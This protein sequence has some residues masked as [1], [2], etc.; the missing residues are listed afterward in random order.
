MHSS[1][2][3]RV[4]STLLDSTASSELD[5]MEMGEPVGEF[6]KDEPSL[7]VVVLSVVWSIS[8]IWSYVFGRA[9]FGTIVNLW[10]K[11]R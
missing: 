3:H 2:T 11:P 6:L 4:G 1:K 9:V 10:L 7:Y 8:R 5:E